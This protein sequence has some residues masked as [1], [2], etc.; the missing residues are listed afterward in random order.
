MNVMCFF[1]FLPVLTCVRINDDD[2]RSVAAY[3]SIGEVAGISVTKWKLYCLL[4]I[5]ERT[6][7][8]CHP[9]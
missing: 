4:I 1:F 7:S 2:S 5:V 6:F 3:I 9:Y 8:C